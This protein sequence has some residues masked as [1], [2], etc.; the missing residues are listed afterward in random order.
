MVER[1][2][3][4]PSDRRIEFRIGIHLGGECPVLR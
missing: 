1:N 3:G 2:S 4:V